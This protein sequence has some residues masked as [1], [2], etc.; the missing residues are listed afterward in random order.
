MLFL[1]RSIRSIAGSLQRGADPCFSYAVLIIASPL[2]FL[3]FLRSSGS[4]HRFS[5]PCNSASIQRFASPSH[6]LSVLCFSNSLLCLSVSDRCHASP[7]LFDSTRGRSFPSLCYA[8]LF[9]FWSTQSFSFAVQFISS[10]LRF[11][12]GQ[13]CSLLFL[14]YALRINANPAQFLSRLLNSVSKQTIS[15]PFPCSSSRCHSFSA[16]SESIP[17]RFRT[18]RK[19]PWRSFRRCCI[20]SSLAAT[21][22]SGSR[23]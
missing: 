10:L 8:P 14:C 21:G 9:R 4:P 22:S 12:S 5:V 6:F 3:S 7:L 13:G 15:L 11:D 1:I 16:H 2:R 18:G 19:E 20:R 23:P 17:L